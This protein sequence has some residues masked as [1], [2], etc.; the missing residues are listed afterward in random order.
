MRCFSTYPKCL[1][2]I[3]IFAAMSV[4]LFWGGDA[5]LFFNHTEVDGT[6]LSIKKN[7]PKLSRC[8]R[9]FTEITTFKDNSDLVVSNLKEATLFPF[10]ELCFSSPAKQL[11]MKDYPLNSTDLKKI[12]TADL[13]LMFCRTLH[14]WIAMRKRQLS[15]GYQCPLCLQNHS[16]FQHSAC[17]Q[18]I[19]ANEHCSMLMIT[20][21][22]KMVA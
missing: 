3:Q 11:C 1:L 12:T 21:P 7:P 20:Y 13:A 16:H 18:Q 17:K 2:S 9:I 5:C 8:V 10:F 15:L 6:S 14:V 22:A 19:L 4:C